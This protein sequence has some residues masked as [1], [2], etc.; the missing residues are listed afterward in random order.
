MTKEL[1]DDIDLSEILGIFIRNKY[2]ILSTTFLGFLFSSIYAF[3]LERIWRGEFQIVLS[4]KDNIVKSEIRSNLGL[5]SSTKQLKTEVK[6]LQSPSVL[7]NIFDYVKENKIEAGRSLENWRFIKWR[8]DQ[9]KVKLVPG[10][11]VLNISYKDTNKGLIIPVLNKISSAY[12]AYSSRDLNKSIQKSLSY[13]KAQISLYKDIRKESI[14]KAQR[15]ALEN[16]LAPINFTTDYDVNKPLDIQ[17]IR[18]SSANEIRFIDNKLQ[19]LN[20]LIE[21][22]DKDGILL[23]SKQLFS[24]SSNFLLSKL[25]QLDEDIALRNDVFNKTDQNLLRI[26][27]ERSKLIDQISKKALSKLKVDRSIALARQESSKRPI[28]VFLKYGELVSKAGKDSQTLSKLENTLRKTLLEEA[29]SLDPWELITKPTLGDTPIGPSRRKIALLGSLVGIIVG[30]L[31]SILI[32]GKKNK[33]YSKNEINR[34]FG[35]N[36]L[37]ETEINDNKTFKEDIALLVNGSLSLGNDE[38]LAIIGLGD[39]SRIYIDK[40]INELNSAYGN[41]RAIYTSNLISASSHNKQLILLTPGMVEKDEITNLKNK[42]LLSDQNIIGW[43][44]IY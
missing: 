20:N 33:A 24:G 29:K 8:E 5:D 42:L 14:R 43:A 39:I 37:L 9:L 11:T 41:K 38:S 25:N 7:M 31:I 30:S 36:L 40:F 4:E 18:V 2:R 10:T 6:I 21:N 44:S 1:D 13:T 28:D 26:R 17:S 22:E 12:Q 15:Y 35:F 34:L 3:S 16:D 19:Q 23:F 32:D 27:E